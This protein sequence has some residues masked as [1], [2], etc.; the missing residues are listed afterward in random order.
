VDRTD[1][2][3]SEAD[4]A[5]VLSEIEDGLW[6]YVARHARDVAATS[7]AVADLTGLTPSA[8]D[9]LRRLHALLSDDVVVFVDE[10]LPALLKG[11]RP[12]APPRLGVGRG[13]VRGPIAWGAT[14]AARA[15]TGGDGTIYASQSAYKHFATPEAL[16]L[17][18]L[19]ASL[20]ASCE[21]LNDTVGWGYADGWGATVARIDGAARA[22]LADHRL[23]RVEEAA[24]LAPLAVPLAAHLAACQRSLRGATRAL[25]RAYERYRDLVECPTMEA[26]RAALRE[27]VLL[28]M[29][30][31]ALY[32]LWALLG[33]A[34]VLD[35]AGW[36]LEA[37]ALV[38]QRPAPF[39]Y[40]APHGV[41]ARLVFQ[42]APVPWRESSRYR[43]LFERYGVAGA[44]RRPDL[45]VELEDGH[46]RRYLLVEVKRT[47][48]P[49]Y[50]ADSVYKVLGYL[51]DF[52]DVFAGQEGARAILLVWDGVADTLATSAPDALV[53]AT[54]RD[55]H[56]RLR[57]ILA[58]TAP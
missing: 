27:R 1:T 45:I 54:H 42:H 6:R 15:R 52:A 57:E 11:L 5:R 33:V 21:R 17:R 46:G 41:T 10:A 14:T 55:Y 22:A 31:D 32:E 13:P 48:D 56:A 53:L 25:A 44:T 38:G 58:T 7:Q 40:R 16:L 43:A 4:R 24:P 36:R 19:L 23:A 50:T 47:R 39:A 8:L 3:W 2:Y 30:D 35:E 28:P 37:A 12:V 34:A 20:V 51:A 29:Q 18:R 49:G 9:A 26:L